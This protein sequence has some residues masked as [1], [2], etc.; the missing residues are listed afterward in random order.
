MGG[1][2]GSRRQNCMTVSVT[3][4]ENKG[5]GGTVGGKERGERR[6]WKVRIQIRQEDILVVKKD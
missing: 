3:Q 5:V 1:G 6:L 2:S 4:G